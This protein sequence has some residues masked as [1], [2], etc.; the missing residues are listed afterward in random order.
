[1][2][3]QANNT[4]KFN[5]PKRGK[6]KTGISY[7]FV[8]DLSFYKTV[9]ELCLNKNITDLENLSSTEI[10]KL[11]RKVITLSNQKII[12]AIVNDTTGFKLPEDLGYLAITRYKS[13]KRAVDWQKSNQ[14]GVKVYHTNF[15]SNGFSARVQHF[16][17]TVSVCTNIGLYKFIPS[18]VLTTKKSIK[19]KEGK[20]YNEMKI[21]DFSTNK[22]K[23]RLKNLSN[24]N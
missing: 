2:T 11:I 6:C 24:N 22:I 21:E 12:N 19:L 7:N 9:K 5:K 18:R 8:N 20:V 16:F 4:I 13:K 3:S 17:K 10:Q 1:M 15:H 14:Y 23:I